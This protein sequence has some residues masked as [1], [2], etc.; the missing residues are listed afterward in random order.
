MD[1]RPLGRSGLTVPVLGW[2]TVKIGRNRGVK[3]PQS[4]DLPSDAQVEALVDCALEC[5]I[6]F[7]DTAPAYGESEER[8]GRALKGRRDRVLLSTKVGEDFDGQRSHYAFDPE[9]VRRSVERS[10]RRLQTDYLDLL[11]LHS[12]GRDR[13]LLEDH[14]LLRTLVELKEKGRVRATGISAKTS[15]GIRLAARELDVVMAPFHR[16]DESLG[17]AL[18]AAAD[19]GC[20]VLAIK[21]FGQGHALGA[22]STPDPV[23][24]A[25]RFVVGQSF[26]HAAV[27]GTSSCDHLRQWVRSLPPST[28]EES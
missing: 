13:D 22:D 6:D 15:E 26:V 24:A 8:L 3:Y 2:G 10:L 28:P 20:G 12:D 5:G 9:S 16:G 1:R 21:V 4:F 27:A 18:R 17:P 7:F 14:D 11:L 25:L 23:A 19:A